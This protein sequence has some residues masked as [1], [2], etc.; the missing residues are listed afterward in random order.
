MTSTVTSAPVFPVEHLPS[1]T[2]LL[3]ESCHAFAVPLPNLIAGVWYTEHFSPKPTGSLQE[4][5]FGN[6]YWWGGHEKGNFGLS[7]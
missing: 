3:E 7:Q 4:A 2:F 1:D 6:E 5:A